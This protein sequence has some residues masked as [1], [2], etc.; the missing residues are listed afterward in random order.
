MPSSAIQN[1]AAAAES[2]SA[3]K[4][5]AKA[6]RTE[7]PAPSASPAPEKAVSISGVDASE[8]SGESPYVRELQKNIRNV[9]KKI[10]NASKTD[11]IIDQH[12]GKSLDELVEAKIINADQRAQRLKK[13]QLEGQLAQYEEQLAQYKKIDEEY[14]SR[15][16]T[17]KATV[18]KALT[19]KFEK[20]K[21]DAINELTEKASADAKQSLHD[22]L[23]ALSQFLRLAAARRSEEADATLDEN[24]ALEGVLLNVYSGDEN[25]VSTMLK[26]IEGS[27][28]QT[29]SVNG[30][31]LQ[32]TF[33]QVK[34]AATAYVSPFAA[35]EAAPETTEPVAESTAPVETDPTVAHAGLTEI[36]STGATEPLTNGHSE[37]TPQ[38]SVPTNADVS[39][40]AANAAAGSEW[41][42]NNTM[43]SSSITQE[44]WVKVPRNP[45]E[46]ETGLNATPAAAGNVQSWADD[47][48][49]NPPE[50]SLILHADRMATVATSTAFL[51]Y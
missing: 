47:Q 15:S 39:D 49:E 14:R 37:P 38:S 34:A 1:P 43:S 24:M 7:S 13:P 11:P 50:V 3:K 6:E 41:D 32:T 48:P 4:K 35:V 9:N 33:A 51:V 42:A 8:D 40:N 16:V 17:D 36:D 22:S 29:H 28:E 45:S 21:A 23:L 46:T 26:L 27:S 10:V 12:K 2:K 25:A 5:K 44:G 18:E 30:D 31:E 19:E 20:E